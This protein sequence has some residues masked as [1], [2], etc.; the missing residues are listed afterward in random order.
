LFDVYLLETLASVG[1]FTVDWAT[2][3]SVLAL[4]VGYLE[5]GDGNTNFD[6]MDDLYLYMALGAVGLTVYGSYEPAFAEGQSLAVQLALLAVSIAGYW[7]LA[8]N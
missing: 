3:G 4:V 7:A 2:V 5:V 6:T 8:H 1:P